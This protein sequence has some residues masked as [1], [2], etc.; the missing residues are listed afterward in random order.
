MMQLQSKVS[1]KHKVPKQAKSKRAFIICDVWLKKLI[2]LA[3]FDDKD[4][5]NRIHS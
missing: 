2:F 3:F 4:M 5:Q 1:S